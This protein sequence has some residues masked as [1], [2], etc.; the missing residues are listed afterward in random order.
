MICSPNSPYLGSSLHEMHLNIFRR[1]LPPASPTMPPESVANISHSSTLISL[2]DSLSYATIPVQQPSMAPY[3]QIIRT[4]SSAT[5]LPQSR[6]FTPLPVS[7]SPLS[8]NLHQELKLFLPLELPPA[9]QPH[10]H[11]EIRASSRSGRMPTAENMLGLGLCLSGSSSPLN[12]QVY[13]L[14]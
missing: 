1:L 13:L 12:T 5:G 6:V 9:P 14:C 8:C 11:H 4:S 3:Y 10:R 2:E 7:H